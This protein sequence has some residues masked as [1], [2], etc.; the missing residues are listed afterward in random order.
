MSEKL[1]AFIVC[2]V[3]VVAGAALYAAPRKTAAKGRPTVNEKTATIQKVEKTDAEWKEQLTPEQYSVLRKQG[4]E[5]AF[6]GK[7]H[8]HHE[9]GTYVCAACGLPLFSSVTKFESGTG[10]PSFWQP[11]APQ[12]VETESD[13]AFGMRRTEVHCARCGGHL[14]HVFEDG[15]PPTGLRYCI[16]SVSLGFEKG[17]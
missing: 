15:P 14:G 8:D 6:T 3:V 2:L 1:I 9:K 7:Y 4:T 10:W 16:N 12:N 5:R 17:K 11:I 13:W